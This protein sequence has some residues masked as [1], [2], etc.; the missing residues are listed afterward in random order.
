MTLDKW[1]FY[2]W[3]LWTV[4]TACRF[5][6]L[7]CEWFRKYQSYRCEIGKD[8]YE[9]TAIEKVRSAQR[10]VSIRDMQQL[11]RGVYM[12]KDPFESHDINESGV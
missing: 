6:W 4:I 3:S 11:A 2:A 10:M 1:V 7:C 12:G 8:S 9:R 5:L